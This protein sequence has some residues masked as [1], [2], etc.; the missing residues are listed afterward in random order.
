MV[1]RVWWLAALVGCGVF[2]R[3]TEDN[4]GKKSAKAQCD[5]AKRC[6]AANFWFTW[7]DEKACQD[8]LEAD[9]DAGVPDLVGCTFDPHAA[10][11]CL[12]AL[13]QSCKEIGR[14]YDA[15]FPPC[16]AVWDCG[17]TNDSSDTGPFAT[18]PTQ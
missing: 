18:P 15:L 6:D 11:D 3:P 17:V 13:D 4:W 8:S 9:Y 16:L 12:K 2:N 10:R 1:K 7:D 14:E 5:Y